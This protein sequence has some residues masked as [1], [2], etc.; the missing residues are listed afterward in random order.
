[1]V[2]QGGGCGGRHGQVLDERVDDS[3]SGFGSAY[4]ITVIVVMMMVVVRVTQTAG[5][6]GT[7]A[8]CAASVGAVVVVD[9]G[10]GRVVDQIVSGSVSSGVASSRII[11]SGTE[12]GRINYPTRSELASV[13]I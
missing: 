10:R 9:D 5:G 13:F 7:G 12:H 4:R 6:S 2:S 11:S 3:I 8:G 1:M